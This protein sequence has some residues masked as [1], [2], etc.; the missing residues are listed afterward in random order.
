MLKGRVPTGYPWALGTVKGGGRRCIID[1]SNWLYTQ[2]DNNFSDLYGITWSVPNGTDIPKCRDLNET[3]ARISSEQVI[4]TANWVDVAVDISSVFTPKENIFYDLYNSTRC[5]TTSAPI[6]IDF[7]YP[8]T[9]IKKFGDGTVLYETV[10]PIEYE[11]TLLT[12]CVKYGMD[13][14]IDVSLIEA[15]KNRDIPTDQFQAR[16]L[17]R[18][19]DIVV[20]DMENTFV[21]L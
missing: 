10:T 18:L 16:I 8:N 2:K 5:T 19:G 12:R 21:L 4:L 20:D 3:G 14:T 7:V 11:K 13:S 6:E 17:S 1:K 9:V 15:L